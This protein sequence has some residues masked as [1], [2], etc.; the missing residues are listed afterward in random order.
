MTSDGWGGFAAGYVGPETLLKQAS[1]LEAWTARVEGEI[2]VEIGVDIR[3]SDNGEALLRFFPADM[4]GHVA[5]E[6][7]LAADISSPDRRLTVTV[8]AEPAEVERFARQLSSMAESYRE[9]AIL[10]AMMLNRMT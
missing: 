5:C 1:R 6:V 7:R 8:A 9:D 10:Q 3:P 4:A 2:V